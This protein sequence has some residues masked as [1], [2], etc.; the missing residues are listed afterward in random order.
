VREKW[1]M[2]TKLPIAAGLIGTQR[3]QFPKSGL[4]LLY[5]VRCIVVHDF[6]FAK[7]NEILIGHVVVRVV[8][9]NSESESKEYI[10]TRV[11]VC[12]YTVVSQQ[13]LNKK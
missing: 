12:L 11:S 9:H 13:T 2:R 6:R 5:R 4:F 7:E 10:F 8:V 3:M 1:R